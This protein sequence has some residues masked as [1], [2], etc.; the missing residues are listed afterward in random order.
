MDSEVANTFTT[1]HQGIDEKNTMDVLKEELLVKK[2]KLHLSEMQESQ[3]QVVDDKN[4]V[5]SSIRTHQS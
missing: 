5:V 3:A 1:K 2:L 4:E